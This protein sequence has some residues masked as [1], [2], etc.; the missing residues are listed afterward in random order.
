[1]AKWRGEKET[2]ELVKGVSVYLVLTVLLG[3]Y[4]VLYL[5]Y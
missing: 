5:D 2:S 3:A 4:W 1:M